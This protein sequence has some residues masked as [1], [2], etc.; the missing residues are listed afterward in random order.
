MSTP[1]E[2]RPIA[3]W[4]RHGRHR[5]TDPEVELRLDRYLQIRFPYRSRTAWVEIIKAGRI[6]VNEQ[7]GRRSQI[8]RAGALIEYLPEDLPEPEVSFD[9]RI[10]YEDDAILAVDKPANLPVHPTGPYFLNTLLSRL[11]QQRNETLDQPGILVVHRL[12]RETSGVVIF[13]KGREMTRRLAPQFEHRT[14]E[15]TY[16]ALVHGRPGSDHFA[17]DCRI[18]PRPGSSVRK[19]VGVVG[20]GEGQSSRTE[21]EVVSRGPD[22]AIL[23][24]HPKTGRMHQIRAH[25]RHAGYPIVGDKIYGLDEEFFV[26]FVNDEGLTPEDRE[27]LLLERQA[28]HAWKL[29]VRHPRHDRPITFVAPFPKEIR[30]VCDTLGLDVPRELFAEE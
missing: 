2:P 16:L 23:A 14:A 28:L 29:T 1:Q 4:V 19:A 20:D 17:V 21:F 24:A 13:G 18:G 5:I 26:R 15:K 6:L 8:V 12:D 7:P 10:L 30:S 27:R 9:Y 25:L 3:D 22:H 11:L